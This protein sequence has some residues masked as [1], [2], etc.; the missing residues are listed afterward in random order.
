MPRPTSPIDEAGP[1]KGN[2]P[3]TLISVAVTPGVSAASA[4][5]TSAKV[6][7]QPNVN[8]LNINFPPSLSQS[9]P[10]T[11]GRGFLL[12]GTDS[13]HEGIKLQFYF[14]TCQAFTSRE[15]GMWDRRTPPSAVLV[16]AR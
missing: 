12:S 3:P 5:V 8:A 7:A 16:E 15:P 11:R 10:L 13:V 1:L 14:R 6:S 4:D 9:G 2:I